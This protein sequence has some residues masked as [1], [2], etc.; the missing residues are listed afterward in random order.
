MS[1]LGHQHLITP[2]LMY[3]SLRPL[4]CFAYLSVF[5]YCRVQPYVYSYILGTSKENDTCL[6]LES[7]AEQIGI[8]T[9]DSRQLMNGALDWSQDFCYY[10]WKPHKG[11]VGQ[12]QKLLFHGDAHIPFG[13]VV[14]FLDPTLLRGLVTI[15][16]F[17]VCAES[18][19]LFASKQHW[20]SC[21]ACKLLWWIA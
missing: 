12:P 13:G 8:R 1:R 2:C 20:L 4:A 3:A 14:L 15:E 21:L 6:S 11:N 19:V 17:H 10:Y 5:R 9:K 18:T 16:H 7:P